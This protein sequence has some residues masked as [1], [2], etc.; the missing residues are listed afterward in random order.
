MYSMRS[1]FDLFPPII[2]VLICLVIPNVFANPTTLSRRG[3]CYG[4]GLDPSK[5]FETSGLCGQPCDGSRVEALGQKCSTNGLSIVSNFFSYCKRLFRPTL[6][7]E[8]QE[9]GYYPGC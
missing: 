8:N 4:G 5:A 9:V 3:L 7:I 6:L 2:L 1:S